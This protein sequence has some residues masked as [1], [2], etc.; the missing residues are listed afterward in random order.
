MKTL[1]NPTCR[2]ADLV[3]ELSALLRPLVF[4]ASDGASLRGTYVTLHVYPATPF[5]DKPVLDLMVERTISSDDEPVAIARGRQSLALELMPHA[6]PPR[7]GPAAQVLARNTLAR[8][9]EDPARSGADKDEAV[10]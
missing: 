2:R 9:L 1:P 4:R 6:S 5:G 8:I 10:A 3:D 7:G